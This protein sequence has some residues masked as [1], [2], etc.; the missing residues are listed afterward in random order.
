MSDGQ[1]DGHQATA[2]TYRAYAQRRAV[3]TVTRAAGGLIALAREFMVTVRFRVTLG[4][5]FLVKV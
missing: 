5:G 3:K 2:N 4:L 1:T